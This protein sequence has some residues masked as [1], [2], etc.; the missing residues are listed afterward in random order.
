MR[1]DENSASLEKS[2]DIKIIPSKAVPQYYFD[3][4]VYFS[5]FALS[6][7]YFLDCI[8]ETEGVAPG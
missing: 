3:I 8:S 7:L 6:A 2:L 4:E 1:K 5:Y